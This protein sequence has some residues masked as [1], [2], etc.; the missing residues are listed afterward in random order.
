MASKEWLEFN[1]KHRFIDRESINDGSMFR[2]VCKCGWSIELRSNSGLPL[3][4][5][6][7]WW[8]HFYSIYPALSK[9]KNIE[10]NDAEV[11]FPKCVKCDN[12]AAALVEKGWKSTQK[13]ILNV[14]PEHLREYENFPGFNIIV[15]GSGEK[16]EPLTISKPNAEENAIE[17]QV[18]GVISS[19]SRPKT[20]T[21]N[22]SIKRVAIVVL[23][24]IIGGA[25]NSYDSAQ[26]KKIAVN[27][28]NMRNEMA[29]NCFSIEGEDAVAKSGPVG[30]AIR[31]NNTVYYYENVIKSSCVV[32]GDGSIFSNPFYNVDKKSPNWQQLINALNYTAKRWNLSEPFYLQCADGWNSPSIGK[33]G[34]CSHHGGVV[35]PFLDNPN[36][37]LV[38][39]FKSADRLY[40]PL[41]EITNATK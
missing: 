17:T 15:I 20:S 25:L 5:K 8:N 7:A 19:V 4:M 35:S 39:Q 22:K 14:C 12:L 23:L 9:T 3:G 34:A 31:Q 32:W 28:L 41:I 24:V 40:G 29:K 38:N 21:P 2:M 16:S 10:N 37:N 36:W 1:K 33:R 11:E 6:V 18:E 13:E 27:N 26:S 30:S